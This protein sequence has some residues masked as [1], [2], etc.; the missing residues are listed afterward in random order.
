MV[1]AW[2]RAGSCWGL[3]DRA[4]AGS[5][6]LSLVSILGLDLGGREKKLKGRRE[7]VG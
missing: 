1:G 3:G 7:P 6:D 5:M 2:G 4:G